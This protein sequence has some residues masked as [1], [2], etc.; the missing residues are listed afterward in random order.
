MDFTLYINPQTPGPEA[1]GAIMD[2]A[3]E[4]A[5]MADEAGFRGIALTHHHFSN[6]N[7][8]GNPFVFG[9][10]LAGHVKRAS[11]LMQVAVAP[12]I[13][14]IQLV[15]DAN[16]LDQLWKGRFIMGLGNGGSPLEFEGMGRLPGQ[17][18]DLMR[19]VLDVAKRAWAHKPGD[20]PLEYKTLHDHG[21][22]RGRIMPGP[23]T[24][25]QPHL[26][27]SALSENGWADAGQLGRPLFFGRVV[28]DG[29]AKAMSLY[30]EAL[31]KA[32]WDEERK[33]FCRR[34]TTMQKTV[35][36]ADTDEEANALIDEPLQK[37]HELSQAAFAAYG[38]EQRRAVTGVSGDDPAVFRQSFVEGATII[39]SPSTFIERLKRYQDVGVNHVALHANFGFMKPEVTRRTLQ[40][41]IDKVMPKFA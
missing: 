21:I 8:Y 24:K 2:A 6:Y 4:N 11:L 20:E 26:A 9:A 32:G 37:L 14:P 17:R 25:D 35:L 41:F 29:A 23:Y 34:W 36:I 1:D 31:E 40:L 38:D 10:Y 13:N 27:R 33:Q 7:T 16:L 19:Q 5:V 39:G 22:I 30:N 18:F 3:V 28:E 12:L 15:E